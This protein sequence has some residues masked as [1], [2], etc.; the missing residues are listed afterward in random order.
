MLPAPLFAFAALLSAPLAL[1]Q[2]PCG[3]WSDGFGAPGVPLDTQYDFECW[4]HGGEQQL[5]ASGVR[6]GTARLLRREGLSWIVAREDAGAIAANL[7]SGDDGSG[8]A[9]YL[10][11][12]A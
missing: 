2:T 3:G 5:F 4:T 11:L 12:R 1:A 7:T 10:G 8:S 9:L 6:Y